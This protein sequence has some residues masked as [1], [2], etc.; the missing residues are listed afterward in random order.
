MLLGYPGAIGADMLMQILGLGAIMLHAAGRGVG[1][2]AADA[3][4]V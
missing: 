1:L 2:A 3:S 4:P